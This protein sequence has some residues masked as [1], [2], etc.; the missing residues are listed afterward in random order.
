VELSAQ[1]LQ[2]EAA[3]GPGD[4]AHGSGGHDSQLL[5]VQPPRPCGVGQV[6]GE[7]AASETRLVNTCPAEELLHIHA[8]EQK[9]LTPAQWA[10]EQQK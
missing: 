7:A 5:R 4:G 8:F 3:R 1:Y 9:T 6:Q 2:G 10:R